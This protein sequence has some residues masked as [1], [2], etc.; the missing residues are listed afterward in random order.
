MKKIINFLI[1]VFTLT[2]LLG[3]SKNKNYIYFETF[4]G[5][6][7]DII[8][9]N[10]E[11]IEL[12]KNVEREGSTFE[13]WYDSL[14]FENKV[15]DKKFKKKNTL[16]FAKWEN[17]YNFI[18]E[19]NT[20]GLYGK[21]EFGFYEYYIPSGKYITSKNSNNFNPVLFIVKNELE[22]DKDTNEEFYPLVERVV[23]LN[24]D[25]D[26]EIIISEDEHVQ[27]SMGTIINFKKETSNINNY[28]KY[29]NV[30]EI[31]FEDYINNEVNLS[32]EAIT[33]IT[34]II[35]LITIV[36]VI[37][38]TIYSKTKNKSS[39]STK[40]EVV[41]SEVEKTAYT[42][43]KDNNTTTNNITSKK[44]CKICSSPAGYW[45]NGL[46][47]KDGRICKKCQ[48]LSNIS[49]SEYI[50]S[51]YKSLTTSDVSK[52]INILKANTKYYYENEK[53]FKVEKNFGFNDKSKKMMIKIKSKY[54]E[55][56]DY[57]N[58]VNIDLFVNN[59]QTIEGGLT[60]AF[61]GGLIYGSTGAIVGSNVSK[62]KIV[63]TNTRKELK[64]QI[65]DD[66]NSILNINV[67]KYNDKVLDRIIYKILHIIES[68][69]RNINSKSNM[70]LSS[71]INQLYQLYEQGIITAEEFQKYKNRVLEN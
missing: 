20:K 2:I 23:Y 12:P 60:S 4:G 3:N 55:I 70:S 42:V 21:E 34:M 62:K 6:I 8:E 57:K 38:V 41:I 64:I 53:D 10:Q 29:K 13:G 63:T 46:K 33:I 56:I 17:N 39:D 58:I 48:K 67:M 45:N 14:L 16:L 19:E 35:M 36:T 54:P 18:I 59:K 24:S 51:G 50:I 25:H 30:E 31:D 27:L 44:N 22:V 47:L 69:S 40:K 32:E 68:N 1:I 7:V 37:S 71:E 43:N 66:N 52:K 28:G 65:Y 15:N 26:K 5:D 9:I 49:K 11:L 61:L